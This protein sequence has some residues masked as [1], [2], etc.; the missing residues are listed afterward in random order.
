MKSLLVLLSIFLILLL[1]S[2][3]SPELAKA[4]DNSILPLPAIPNWERYTVK[5]EEFSALLPTL[6]AMSTHSV[7]GEDS[8]KQFKER[9]LGAYSDGVVYAIHTVENQKRNPSLDDLIRRFGGSSPK[10]SVR[11]LEVGGFRGKEYVIQTSDRRGV[12]QYFVGERHSY[13]FRAVGSTLGN[14]EEGMARFFASL[15]LERKPEGKEVAD[16][17]GEQPTSDLTNKNDIA[18]F[19]GKEVSS[20]ASVIT[21]PEPSYTEEARQH[22]TTGTVVLRGVFSSSGAIINIRVVSGLPS[23]LTGKAIGAARQIRFI[24]AIKDSNFVSQ[25]VQIEYNFNLY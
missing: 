20:K 19:T 6:P 11:Q 22:Q 9:V 24:P 25:W 10:D 4:R 16:G 7:R 21:R 1:P 18:P 23:G 17:P 5:D 12:S 14:P 15:R 2:V 13:V 3:R 8:D